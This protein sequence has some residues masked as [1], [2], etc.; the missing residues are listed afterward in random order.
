MVGHMSP[1]MVRYYTHISG[2]AQRRRAAE[3]PDKHTDRT[4]FVDTFVDI[5][6]ISESK[7]SKLLN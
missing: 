4:R 7:A 3:M 1:A 5:G 6:K 2:D